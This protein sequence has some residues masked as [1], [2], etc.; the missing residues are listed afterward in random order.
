MTD[1]RL[2]LPLLLTLTGAVL[3]A[4]Y[5]YPA[6]NRRLSM[7]Q[8]AWLL[9][10][11][12]LAAFVFILSRLPAIADGSALTFAVDWM[13]SLG[14]GAS[15]YLD[16]LSALF[17]LLVSGIGTL[18]VVYTGYYFKGDNSAWRFLAYLFLFM[19]MML[20]VLLAGDVITLFVFWEG[21]S[22]TSFLLIAYKYKD[23]AARRGA[24]KSLFITGGGGIALLAGLLFVGLTA[25]WALSGCV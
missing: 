15:L 20:G 21:T 8:A 16:N 2:A 10:L 4:V 17:L 24:F 1:M 5:G 7:T 14:M 12:P 13:P 11:F 22:L 6:L 9:A 3:A 25:A 19:T 18:V 23:K